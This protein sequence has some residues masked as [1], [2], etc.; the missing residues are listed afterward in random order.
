MK[1]RT[2]IKLGQKL[3]LIIAA[4]LYLGIVLYEIN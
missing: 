1:C 2:N 3:I 4:V